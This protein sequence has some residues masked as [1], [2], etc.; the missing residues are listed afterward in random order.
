MNKFFQKIIVIFFLLVI[1]PV[2]S[3]LCLQG[4]LDPATKINIA[5][6]SIR[7]AAVVGNGDTCHDTQAPESSK[8]VS[9]KNTKHSAA[10]PCCVDG[11]HT[12]VVSYYK[13]TNPLTAVALV[14][15]TFGKLFPP[16]S[17]KIVAYQTPLI[18]PPELYSV[19]TTILRV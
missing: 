5:Q 1:F 4:L 2:T 9:P 19:K 17:A 6:D 16:T 12:A 7:V 14:L 11:D 13:F 10:L 15:P 3:G 8:A 18:P